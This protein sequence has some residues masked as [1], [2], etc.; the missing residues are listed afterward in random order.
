MRITLKGTGTSWSPQYV[1]FSYV[2]QSSTGPS[3]PVSLDP[4]SE[5]AKFKQ[6][7][8]KCKRDS[9]GVADHSPRPGA[10]RAAT[11]ETGPCSSDLQSLETESGAG[12]GY[13]Y[14]VD[15]SKSELGRILKDP[16]S[17]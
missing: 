13:I 1:Q 16:E 8:V 17:S 10:A 4:G 3:F 12:R 15:L 9:A 14:P 2:P 5:V 7:V 11:A 6:C